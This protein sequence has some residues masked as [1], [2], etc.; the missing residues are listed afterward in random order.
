MKHPC[1]KHTARVILS[2]RITGSRPTRLRSGIGMPTALLLF[3]SVFKVLARAIK[4]EKAL[5]GIEIGKEVQLSLFANF[6]M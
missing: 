6:I 3:N 1:K 5:K 2:G 4:Q